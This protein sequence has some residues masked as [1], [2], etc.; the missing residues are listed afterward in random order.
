MAGTA[1]SWRGT[2]ISIG[3]GQLWGQLAIPAASSRITLATDGT[4]DATAHPSAYH[5][6]IT[7]SGAEHKILPK[8]GKVRADEFRN[9]LATYVDDMEMSIAASL[10]AVQDATVIQYLLSGVGT[11]ATGSGFAQ[12]TVGALAI[13]YQCVANI[14]P[15]FADP[16]KFAVFNIYSTLNEAGV[17]F[18]SGRKTQGETPVNFMAYEI[19]SRAAIDTAGNYWL[20][21]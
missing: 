15:T 17:S 9:P 13:T 14:I 3:Q 12:N 1:P 11:Y 4:P 5:F 10:M 7:S 19:T 20:Q 2:K 16:T 21:V 6:G 18:K 8:Y